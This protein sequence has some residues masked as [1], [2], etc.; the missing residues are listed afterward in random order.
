P[1]VSVRK[2]RCLGF[3]RK[4]TTREKRRL[5]LRSRGD[6]AFE[7]SLEEFPAS[8][9][10]QGNRIATRGRVDH[11]HLDDGVDLAAVNLEPAEILRHSGLFAEIEDRGEESVE[12]VFDF[13]EASE[14]FDLRFDRSAIEDEHVRHEHAIGH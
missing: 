4:A 9:F 14:T 12:A 1:F 3:I 5:Y 11:G 6:I 8:L 10:S 7:R 13:E 2:I